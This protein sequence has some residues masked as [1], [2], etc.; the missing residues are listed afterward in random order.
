[1]TRIELAET[2]RFAAWS[3]DAWQDW[4]EEGWAAQAETPTDDAGYPF[5]VQTASGDG[6][7]IAPSTGQFDDGGRGDDAL[8]YVT[9]LHPDRDEGS[10][11]MVTIGPCC[12]EDYRQGPERFIEPEPLGEAALVIWY[13]AQLRNEGTPGQQYCWSES[14][15]QDGV[16]VPLEYPCPSGALFV[17][18]NA[19]RSP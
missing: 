19:R 9:R 15:L 11:D 5:R 3:G 16:Y 13:V 12:N 2:A 1:V 8:V 10:A 14:I 7:Y 6:F 4:T 18:L 17:P